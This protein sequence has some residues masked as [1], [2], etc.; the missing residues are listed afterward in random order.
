MKPA[1]AKA[2]RGFLSLDGSID[3]RCLEMAV[4]FLSRDRDPEK[5][6]HGVIPYT[7]VT[8]MLG[9]RRQ[10]VETFVRRGWLERGYVPGRKYAAGVTR[11][12]YR[13]FT[14][15]TATRQDAERHL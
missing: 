6:P 9:V 11:E 13:R 14:E 3:S 15:R 2:L 12:S 5:D 7:D 1:T 4:A 10:T 8:R